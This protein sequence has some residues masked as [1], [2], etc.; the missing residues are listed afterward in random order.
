MLQAAHLAPKYS[1]AEK[2]I[3]LQSLM[4]K[5]GDLPIEGIV[6]SLKGPGGEPVRLLI[7]SFN[8]DQGKALFFR[9]AVTRRLGEWGEGQ[10]PQATLA[11]AVHASTNAPI[12]FFDRAR[13]VAR[14]YGSI[15][16]WSDHRLQQPCRGCGYRGNNFRTGSYQS[17]RVGVGNRNDI[18]PDL[19]SKHH[20]GLLSN[21][22]AR[23]L[24]HGRHRNNG[25]RHP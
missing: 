20:G 7:V 19:R 15:L 22:P 11:G 25:I 8:Y 4:P 5:T 6:G 2:L 13:Y 12:L 17:E 14:H 18:P 3:A 16:G 10:S 24:Y 9:S 1:A 21:S 23:F